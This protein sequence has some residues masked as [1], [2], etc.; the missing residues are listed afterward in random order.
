MQFH[1]A[2][3]VRADP[4]NLVR[5]PRSPPAH[6]RTNKL[7]SRLVG[8]Q[9]SPARVGRHDLGANLDSL[10]FEPVLLDKG[11]G[12]EDG[13]AGAVRGRAALK[14]SDGAVDRAGLFDLFDG[15]DVSEL[16]VRVVLG[17]L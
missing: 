3:L 7:L 5:I 4:S 12:A 15:V 11:F 9:Q 13:G 10:S 1:G 14:E 8:I 6:V 17:V 16:R 2:N